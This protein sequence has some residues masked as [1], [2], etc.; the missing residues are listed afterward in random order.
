[1]IVEYYTQVTL[2]LKHGVLITY[3]T[4]IPCTLRIS[5]VGSLMSM[6]NPEYGKTAMLSHQYGF[7][8]CTDLNYDYVLDIIDDTCIN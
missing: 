5:R 8:Y 6:V 7:K 4:I 3:C 1:M 2:V